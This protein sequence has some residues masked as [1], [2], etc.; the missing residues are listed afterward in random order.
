MTLDRLSERF[1]LQR[2]AIWRHMGRHVTDERKA[3][4]LIGPAKIAE[5][6]D[7]AAEESQS[8]LDYYGILRSALFFQL[9]KLAAKNDAAGV[10]MLAGRLTDVLGAIGKITGQISTFANS[11]IIN[12][13][14]NVQIL[15]S[16]P[17]AD[18]QAGLLRVCVAHPEARRDIIALFRDLDGKYGA[19][20]P[21]HVPAALAAP[22]RGVA[23][24]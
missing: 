24:G 10:A 1:G 2:D 5:L 15:N 18:L 20:P 17:F 23:N 9:D 6:A 4:Y 21:G 22:S 3:G 12:V 13:Q 11:T 8:V 14:N 16:P 19:A 7:I